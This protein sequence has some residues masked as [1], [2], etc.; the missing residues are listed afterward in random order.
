MMMS[1]RTALALSLA[2][3]T[4]RLPQAADQAPLAVLEAWARAT[5][6]GA[7]T[8]A[9]YL[10]LANPGRE[11]DRLVGVWTDAAGRVELHTHEIT[12]GVARMQ[13]VE[14]LDIPAGGRLVLQ[15]DGAHLMLFGLRRP[16]NPGDRLVLTLRFAK[17]GEMAVT[18]QVLAPGSGGP[19]Q[20]PHHHPS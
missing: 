17:A 1:R 9:A 15:P 19:A 14:G 13:A 16:L 18:A 20:P 5:P 10:T 11:T 8:A 3:L 7:R 6:P 4:P 2:A 12:E